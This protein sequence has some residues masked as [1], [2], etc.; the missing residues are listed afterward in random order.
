[1]QNRK[2]RILVLASG[3]GSTFEFL[4]RSQPKNW[5]LCGLLVNRE[6]CGALNVAKMQQI[7]AGICSQKDFSSHAEWDIALAHKAKEF[8]PDLIVL[9]GFLAKLGV[10]FLNEFD[11]R[12]LNTHPSLLPKYGGKGMYGRRVHEK[13]I[14][15]EEAVTGTTIHWVNE[16]YDS[17]NIIAQLEI[18][19]HKGETVEQLES[20]LKDK[21]KQFLFQTLE[22]LTQE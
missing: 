1:M 7:P 15:N 18:P 10:A 8:Q 20:R 19:V 16:E 22:K 11:G 4:A 9:A 21:E 17:G 14:E 6:D 13:V 12:I 3:T 5:T 2:K